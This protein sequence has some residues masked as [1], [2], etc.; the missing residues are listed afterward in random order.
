MSAK[1]SL[2]S[3]YW[4]LVELEGKEYADAW[5]ERLPDEDKAIIDEEMLSIEAEEE[6]A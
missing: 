3:M 6:F 1:T 4:T 5:V 2:L